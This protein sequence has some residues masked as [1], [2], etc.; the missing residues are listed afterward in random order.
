[1][2]RDYGLRGWLTTPARFAPLDC[3]Q[4]TGKAIRILNDVCISSLHLVPHRSPD[5][6]KQG[7]Q[8][9]IVELHQIPPKYSVLGE[10]EVCEDFRAHVRADGA[11]KLLERFHVKA[12]PHL[13]AIRGGQM[14]ALIS[15]RETEG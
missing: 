8:F 9:S 11:Q 5:F 15:H 13:C 2:K 10:L 4:P 14:V 3:D 1:M 7:L 12:R 6:F